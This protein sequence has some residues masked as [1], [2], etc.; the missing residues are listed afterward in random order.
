MEAYVERKLRAKFHNDPAAVQRGL[1]TARNKISQA[2]AREQDFP[3][4]RV[5]ETRE[6]SRNDERGRESIGNDMGKSGARTN[7]REQ[8]WEQNRDIVREV[9]QQRTQDQRR[10]R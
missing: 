10:E 9:A 2:I 5:V 8:I 4:P 6:T 7:E 3:K 1:S